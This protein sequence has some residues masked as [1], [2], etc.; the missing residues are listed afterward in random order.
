M[1]QSIVN[2]IDYGMTMQEA[3]NAKKVH[4]QWLPDAILLEEGTLSVEDSIN[5]TKYGHELRST[6]YQL[7]SKS[8]NMPL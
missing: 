5:L 7:A 1:F 6:N 2:V 8:K 3:V 4:S